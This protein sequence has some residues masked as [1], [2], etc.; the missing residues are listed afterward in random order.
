MGAVA[1]E[2]RVAE[3]SEY[4][5]HDPTVQAPHLDGRRLIRIFDARPLREEK[6]TFGQTHVGAIDIGCIDVSPIAN[7]VPSMNVLAMSFPYRSIDDLLRVPGD[8]IGTDMRMCK[9]E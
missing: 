6:E 7:L 5:E 2:F 1:H 4:D 3:R 9:V 8:Q